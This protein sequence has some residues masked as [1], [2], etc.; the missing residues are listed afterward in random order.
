MALCSAKDVRW[1]Y[2]AFF[3]ASPFS[4]IPCC[5]HVSVVL[6]ISLLRSSS[7][8]FLLTFLLLTFLLVSYKQYK[9]MPPALLSPFFFSLSPWSLACAA[10]PLVRSV[11]GLSLSKVGTYAHLSLTAPVQQCRGSL[12]EERNSS[13]ADDYEDKCSG[14]WTEQV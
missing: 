7:S 5:S 3:C 2:C 12:L 6:L 11:G 10:S 13:S 14:L 8:S 1:F 9:V 4:W